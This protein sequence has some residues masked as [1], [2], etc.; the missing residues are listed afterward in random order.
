MGRGKACLLDI[1]VASTVVAK[2]SRAL[3]DEAMMEDEEEDDSTEEGKGRRRG[4]GAK[5]ACD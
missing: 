4:G 1:Q 2:R 5:E 3:R